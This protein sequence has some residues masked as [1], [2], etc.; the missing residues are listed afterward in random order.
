M[1][2]R[3]QVTVVKQ[4]LP[5]KLAGWS[6]QKGKETLFIK[7]QAPA[8]ICESSAERSPATVLAFI[9]ALQADQRRLPVLDT[10]NASC[11]MV[12]SCVSND[13]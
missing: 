5:A 13:V 9:R 3:H 8:T 2:P 1:T 6:H 4:P 11:C 7:L 12:S 10:A